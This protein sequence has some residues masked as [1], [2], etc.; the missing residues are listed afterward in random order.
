MAMRSRPSLTKRQR[1][2]ARQLKQQ[3]KTARRIESKLQK[4]SR[5]TLSEGQDPDIAGILP[6]PQPAPAWLQS[7]TRKS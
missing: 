5:A 7:P 4:S 2:M 3:E 1:E 6:G